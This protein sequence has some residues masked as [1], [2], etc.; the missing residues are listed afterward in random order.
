MA[1]LA[2][3]LLCGCFPIIPRLY[4]HFTAIIPYTN[5]DHN[6]TYINSNTR[7]G[8]SRSVDKN[9]IPLDRRDWKMLAGQGSVPEI[10][11]RKTGRERSESDDTAIESAVEGDVEMGIGKR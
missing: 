2:F 3:G 8:G 10:P 11:G 1:E 7:L 9:G 4:Q 5:S 6:A